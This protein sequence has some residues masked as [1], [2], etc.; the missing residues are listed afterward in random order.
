MKHLPG[1]EWWL[2]TLTEPHGIIELTDGPHDDRSGVEQA[3]YLMRGLGL[4]RGARYA[5]AEVRMTEVKPKSHGAN[6][7]AIRTVRAVAAGG[8]PE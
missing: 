2:V 1:T 7:E 8:S 6:E 3:A 5:A 4:Q